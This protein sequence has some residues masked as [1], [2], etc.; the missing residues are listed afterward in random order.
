MFVTKQGAAVQ[1]LGYGEVRANNFVRPLAQGLNLV[2]GGYP[3]NQSANGSG[4]RQMNL[5]ASF[6]GSR[7]F[8]TADSF[9]VWQG[10]ASAG[11]NGYDT[12]YLLHSVAPQPVL[13]QWVKTGDAK[14]TSKDTAT[15][16][17][18]NRAVF[19]RAAAALPG[20]TIPMPWTP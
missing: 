17:L 7:D 1:L 19:T 18:G 16:M 20:Y 9:F 15:L 14:L 13:S 5:A 6:F 2:G 3:L 11:A 4:G 12:Y 8:K 10:D